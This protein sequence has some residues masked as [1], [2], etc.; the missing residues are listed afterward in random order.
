MKEGP[1]ANVRCE[2]GL[3]SI[4]LPYIF[5]SLR[6]YDNVIACIWAKPKDLCLVE[7]PIKGKMLEGRIRGTILEERDD[8]CIV[9][10]YSDGGDERKI[11]VPRKN[12]VMI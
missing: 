4:N 10:F 6:D 11:T 9:S 5:V 1:E 2:I 8:S 3:Q 7:Q 12:L